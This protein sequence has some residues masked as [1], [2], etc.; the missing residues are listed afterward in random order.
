[1][2]SKRTLQ[3]ADPVPIAAPSYGYLEPNS[4]MTLGEGLREYYAVHPDLFSPEELAGREELGT[5][6]QFF[7]AHDACHVLFGLDTDLV[8]EALADTWTLA[9]TN[10]KWAEIKS[11]FNRPEQRSFFADLFAEIGWWSTIWKTMTAV[12]KVAIALFRARKMTKKWPIFEWNDYLAR[13]L[14]ELR[15]EFGIRVLEHHVRAAA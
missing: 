8:D 14:V 3:P 2:Q 10:V 15:E 1:M 4:T 13:P 12:P 11:Y 7:A 6:G 5:L 9:G